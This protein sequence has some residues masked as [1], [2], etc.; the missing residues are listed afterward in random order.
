MNTKVNITSETFRPI[1]LV[2][3]KGWTPKT[4]E[5]KNIILRNR[6][7]GKSRLNLSEILLTYVKYIQV[8]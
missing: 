8:L 2:T 3:E 5:K 4:R 1:V 7:V 6:Q